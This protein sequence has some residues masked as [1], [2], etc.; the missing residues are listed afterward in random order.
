MRNIVI[1]GIGKIGRRY[2][3]QCVEC[4]LSGLKLVDSS[5]D[6]W[7]EQYNGMRIYSPRE[8]VWGKQ[9]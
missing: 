5:N 1:Y 7:G 8:I 6:M 3:D 4:Q 9:I 2:V